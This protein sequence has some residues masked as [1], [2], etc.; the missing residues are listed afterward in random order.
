M[1]PALHCACAGN[2]RQKGDRSQQVLRLISA[3]RARSITPGASAGVAL[4]VSETKAA[5]NGLELMGEGAE[6][7]GGVLQFAGC[8]RLL[9]HHS[10][11]GF[12]RL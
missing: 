1:Q 10:P 9:F 3:T 12:G 5:D 7:F 4:L 11:D 2:A 8:P 6:L